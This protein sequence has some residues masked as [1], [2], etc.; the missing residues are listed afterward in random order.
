MKTLNTDDQNAPSNG[1]QVVQI[2]SSLKDSVSKLANSLLQDGGEV[3][4]QVLPEAANVSPVL[5]IFTMSYDDVFA[6][7]GLCIIIAT[8][9]NPHSQ[10]KCCGKSRF[11]N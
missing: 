2:A 7:L 5:L 6:N 4:V 8:S 1:N 11:L 10:S 3:P 9:A